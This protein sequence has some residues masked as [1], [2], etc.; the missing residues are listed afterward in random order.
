MYTAFPS[1]SRN[2]T[3]M[4]I[5]H[6]LKPLSIPNSVTVSVLG[7]SALVEAT[8]SSMLAPLDLDPDSSICVSMD[9]E[10]NI[11]R[12]V[13]VSIIQ[14]APHSEPSSIYVIPVNKYSF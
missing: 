6:G 2:L 1:L 14:L 7:N 12:R 11:S 4:A 9:A 5:A 10:W 8:L 13:G 3:P